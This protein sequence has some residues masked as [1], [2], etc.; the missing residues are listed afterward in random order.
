MRRNPDDGTPFDGA[1]GGIG[2]AVSVD[3]G[4]EAVDIHEYDDSIAVV[5]DVPGVDRDDISLNC[6]GRTLAIRVADG[7]R[8]SRVRVDLPGYVDDDS[9]ETAFNNG[10]LEVTL[11]RDDDPANIGFH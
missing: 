10:V 8:R 1:F 7:S 3:G 2:R 5:A 4:T 11:D 6:D 9:A